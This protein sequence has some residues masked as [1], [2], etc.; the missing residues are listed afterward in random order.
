[1]ATGTERKVA[2]DSSGARIVDLNRKCEACG[3]LL[4]VE[5]APEH[6]AGCLCEHRKKIL[7]QREAVQAMV[8]APSVRPEVVA[9]LAAGTWTAREGKS[10][11]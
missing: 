8:L 4:D 3:G 1:M 6:A 7:A 2:V 5:P 11:K 10:R 9:Q